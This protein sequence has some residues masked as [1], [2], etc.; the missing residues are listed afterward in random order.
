MDRPEVEKTALRVSDARD[1]PELSAYVCWMRSIENRLK[2]YMQRV[3]DVLGK[4]WARHIEGKWWMLKQLSI[5]P[6]YYKNDFRQ[7][8]KR[9]LR[10][11]YQKVGY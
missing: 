7:R 9:N 1:V 4:E 6:K 3:E 8:I 2:D 5:N 10:S 11:L